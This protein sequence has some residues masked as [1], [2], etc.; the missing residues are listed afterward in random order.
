MVEFAVERK[1]GEIVVGDVRD[2]AKNGKLGRKSN[3]KVSNWS[4]G[5]L[6]KHIEYKAEAEGIRVSLV[7]EA[8]STQTCPN[9]GHRKKP[10]GRVYTCPACGFRGHRDA[11]GAANI[12][13]LYLFGE[14]ARMPAHEPK[15]RFPYWVKR[16]PADTRQVA[17]MQMREATGL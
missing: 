12:L 17:R 8:Y 2:V 6:R 3:H 7:N 16:S 15:Y 1:A 4:H 11:V 13:S 5:R 9:C 10:K 14:L